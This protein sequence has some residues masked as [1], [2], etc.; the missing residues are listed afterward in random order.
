MDNYQHTLT[1][2]NLFKKKPHQI[3]DMFL[4]GK[5]KKRDIPSVGSYSEIYS[6]IKEVDFLEFIKKFTIKKGNPLSDKKHIIALHNL[7]LRKKEWINDITSWKRKSYN[8]DKQ[9]VSLSRHLLCKYDIPSFMDKCWYGTNQNWIDWFIHIGKGGNIRTSKI[10]VI[11]TKKMAFHFLQSPDEYTPNEALRW[12][13]IHGLGGNERMARGIIESIIGN[14]FNNDI[15]WST[16]I[17]FFVR[18]PMIDTAQISPLIDYISYV[19]FDG[20]RV[21]D[22]G[23]LYNTPPSNPSFEIKG[24]TI[25]AL[26]RGMNTWHKDI[27]KNE[28]RN[29][30]QN[31]DGY[32]IV[33]FTFPIL[34]KV[35]LNSTTFNC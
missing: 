6:Y 35:F 8:S 34:S 14:D 9:I 33:D 21:Y 10:P 24:R 22:N 23:G 19:K 20:D 29:V 26:M 16:I 30:P 5:I 28:K 31:W 18:N 1:K 3:I 2:S 13:Q 32:E 17:H 27:G 11:L 7:F 12:A 4:N 15:F 25:D